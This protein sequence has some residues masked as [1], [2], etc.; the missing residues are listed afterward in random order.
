MQ[1]DL[2]GILDYFDLLKKARPEG[3]GS[4]AQRAWRR[5]KGILLEKTKFYQK[6][7]LL[8]EKLIAAS[9]RQKDGYIKVKAIL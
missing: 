8:A 5:R 3:R 4:P 2:S 7:Q 6:M 9:S 1:K